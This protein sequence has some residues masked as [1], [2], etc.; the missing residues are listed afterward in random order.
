MPTV[1][2]GQINV[3]NYHLTVVVMDTRWESVTKR[4]IGNIKK[5][6]IF[7]PQITTQFKLSG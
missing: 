6:H 2:N 4:G 1:R 3:G 5:K 7:I